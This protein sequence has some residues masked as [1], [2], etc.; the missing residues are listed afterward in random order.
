MYDEEDNHYRQCLADAVHDEMQLNLDEF[1]EM[2][3]T[4][5]SY[6]DLIE[7]RIN[8]TLEARKISAQ[9]DDL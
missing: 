9:E 3:M 5:E 7:R 1:D 8:A 2:E 4:L 6:A